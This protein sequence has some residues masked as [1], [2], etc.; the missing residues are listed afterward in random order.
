MLLGLL[1]IYSLSQG[2][3]GGPSLAINFSQVD[4]DGV[5]GY[6]KLGLNLGG[7]VYY[8]FNDKIA[9]QPEILFSQ[10]GAREVNETMAWNF[11]ANYFDVPVILRIT[12]LEKNFGKLIAEVGPSFG[13]LINAKR[14]LAPIIQNVTP[15]YN[16]LSYEFH[17]GF[18]FR[19]PQG[20]MVSI[21]HS[22]SFINFR[23]NY[24]PRL[25]WHRYISIMLRYDLKK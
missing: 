6:K 19:F 7:F 20:L 17:A 8:S 18:G 23:P 11:R 22:T 14:G 15:E 4:G 13:Y 1:P 10:K 25:F 16:K 5:G 9:L 21:R 2:F 3:G 12:A 24:Y